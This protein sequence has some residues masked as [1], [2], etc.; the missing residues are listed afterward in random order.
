MGKESGNTTN[1]W[2][3]L[4]KVLELTLLDGHSALSGKQIGLNYAQLGLNPAH[5]L[6]DIQ[7]VKTA[8]WQQLDYL[9]PGM[10]TAAN[11]CTRA[12]ANLPV[13]FLS[14]FMGC[15]DSGYDMR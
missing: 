10:E 14:T 3:N 8:F 4:A 15:L 11:A 9:L 7:R 1:S 5:P 12:L 2:L 6:A 13:P